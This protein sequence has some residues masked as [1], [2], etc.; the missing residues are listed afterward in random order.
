MNRLQVL[1]V[2]NNQT[3]SKR[4][5][6]CATGNPRFQEGKILSRTLWEGFGISLFCFSKCRRCQKWS[7]VQSNSQHQLRRCSQHEQRRAGEPPSPGGR[8]ILLS[9]YSPSS[10]LLSSSPTHLSTWPPFSH[11]ITYSTTHQLTNSPLHLLTFPPT[12]LLATYSPLHLS[13]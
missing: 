5:V 4:M 8:L 9:T 2:V 13:T 3:L 11:L 10:H 12:H 6:L 1:I 7:D